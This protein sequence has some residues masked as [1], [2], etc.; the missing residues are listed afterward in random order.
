MSVLQVPLGV[1]ARAQSGSRV[2][3]A[4]DDLV[5]R[6]AVKHFEAIARGQKPVIQAPWYFLGTYHEILNVKKMLDLEQGWLDDLQSMVGD[7]ETDLLTQG[8]SDKDV[9]DLVQEMA[10]QIDLYVKD[11]AEQA[12]IADAMVSSLRSPARERVKAGFVRFQTSPRLLHLLLNGRFARFKEGGFTRGLMDAHQALNTRAQ[13][14]AEEE[15]ARRRKLAEEEEARRRKLAEEEEARRRKLAEEEEARRKKLALEEKKLAE[16]EEAHRRKLAEEEEAPYKSAM[17]MASQSLLPFLPSF[18][19][20]VLERLVASEALSLPTSLTPTAVLK[21]AQSKEFQT[22]VHAAVH[23]LASP[24]LEVWKQAPVR[25]YLPGEE[26]EG[27]SAE[28]RRTFIFHFIDQ[29]CSGVT[30]GLGYDRSCCLFL[31]SRGTGK[32]TIMRSVALSVALLAHGLPESRRKV[33]TYWGQ[34]PRVRVTY[35]SKPFPVPTILGQE[36]PLIGL[37]LR[38]SDEINGTRSS[39]VK[40]NEGVNRLVEL[41]GSANASSFINSD[42]KLLLVIDELNDFLLAQPQAT[43]GLCRT[44]ENSGG[45]F[46]ALTGSSHRLYDMLFHP[47]VLGADTTFMHH[48]K[49]DNLLSLNNSKVMSISPLRP[50]A[51]AEEAIDYLDFLGESG[52]HPGILPSYRAF[53]AHRDSQTTRQALIRQVI[54][55]GSTHRSLT[56]DAFV[57][58]QSLQ[59]SGTAESDR[60]A[61]QATVSLS[62][63]DL[64][65]R[66]QS[67]VS[68]ET[69]QFLSSFGALMLGDHEVG[70]KKRAGINNDLMAEL[71]D[72]LASDVANGDHDKYLRKLPAVSVLRGSSSA[73]SEDSEAKNSAIM[74]GLR[75]LA[76][77]GQIELSPFAATLQDQSVGPSNWTMAALCQLLAMTSLLTAKEAD[78]LFA[79]RGDNA[80]IG[81]ALLAESVASFGVAKFLSRCK[82]LVM[83]HADRDFELV[84]GEPS[85]GT[86]ARSL[87]PVNTWRSVVVEGSDDAKG[88]PERKHI[89][90]ASAAIPR[91][92]EFFFSATDFGGDDVFGL[93][94]DAT[95]PR[96]VHLLMVQL[97]LS[98]DSEKGVKLLGD[99]GKAAI[100]RFKAGQR[101]ER[102]PKSSSWASLAVEAGGSGIAEVVIWCVTASNKRMSQRL[103]KSLQEAI[104]QGQEMHL[105]TNRVEDGVSVKYNWCVADHEIM[106]GVWSPRIRSW[107]T[108]ANYRQFLPLD[109]GK[110]DE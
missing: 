52:I 66:V 78:A 106:A 92:G 99:A 4:G 103:K 49:F 32:S 86:E 62:L 85:R 16:E 39:I 11:P 95:D 97:K 45:G 7:I 44:L 37:G 108:L 77:D 91:L 24:D 2:E 12:V 89:M 54:R 28:A 1:H 105:G 48:G 19:D 93:F 110:T 82:P 26:L 53:C 63:T 76:D 83:A 17:G 41:M 84:E 58:G 47:E 10:R 22:S 73:S 27:E 88:K 69:L 70:P 30:R 15:E 42:S 56:R 6:A 33:K 98:V 81:E 87:E 23:D 46:F 65:R 60:L 38:A 20:A 5:V 104:W 29:A 36:L 75:A 74:R 80:L 61:H 68:D 57:T 9:E 72:R 64:F 13:K 21:L 79:P 101:A 18:L 100:E 59:D 71:L 109:D 94:Q 34:S 35:I 96:R 55:N 31:G 51:R 90:S 14:L 25:L 107:A 3:D 43:M 8:R 40:S 67:S 102:E 50:F